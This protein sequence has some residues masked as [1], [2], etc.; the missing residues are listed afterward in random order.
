MLSSVLNNK[1]TVTLDTLKAL[2]TID[3]NVLSTRCVDLL[4]TDKFPARIGFSSGTSGLLALQCYSPE[5]LEAVKWMKRQLTDHA[6][7][8]IEVPIA[9]KMS[10]NMHGPPLPLDEQSVIELPLEKPF[11]FDHYVDLLSNSQSLPFLRNGVQVLIG[12]TGRLK[13]LSLLLDRANCKP[14]EFSLTTV[15]ASTDQLTPRWRKVVED[16]TG[17][18]VST[19]YGIS[20]I[21]V[22]T[23]AECSF[24]GGYPLSPFIISEILDVND[25]NDA[26]VGEL[27]FT[28]L[29]PFN[30][31][32]SLIRY[33][34]GDIV[35]QTG[36]DLGN[37]C[38]E[39]L[40]R[41]SQS[42]VHNGQLLLSG[43]MIM[44]ILDDFP[45]CYRP[46]DRF[47][48]EFNINIPTGNPQ[49]DVCFDV[50][51]K[52]ISLCVDLDL[53]TGMPLVNSGEL[54]HSISNSLKNKG[55]MVDGYNYDI[56]FLGR[57]N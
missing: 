46:Y 26:R 19:I 13:T 2:P 55:G 28:P 10:S 40:G 20:E 22:S 8:D 36:C 3:K 41:K 48:S 44:D 6:I 18:V 50:E 25:D 57:S 52:K 21:V 5:E 37:G 24:C 33:R 47:A 45:Q 42:V 35:R 56:K 30:S 12:S 32:Q 23:A 11:H 9:I 51:E 4:T 27:T 14:E 29:Y 17:A 38:I 54:F 15:F 34:T 53:S 49:F 31:Y 7:G 39:F 16:A 1:R 43:A